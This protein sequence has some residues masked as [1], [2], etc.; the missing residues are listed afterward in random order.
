MNHRLV[1]N[2]R[3]T[4]RV[5]ENCTSQGSQPGSDEVDDEDPLTLLLE[6]LVLREHIYSKRMIP[7]TRHT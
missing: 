5:A 3:T 7:K 2:C 1:C 6:H 4:L